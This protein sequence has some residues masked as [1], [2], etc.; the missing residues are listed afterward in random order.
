MNP[1][2]GS[3]DTAAAAGWYFQFADVKGISSWNFLQQV[4]G[5][6]HVSKFFLWGSHYMKMNKI[7]KSYRICK[8]YRLKS[9]FT[10]IFPNNQYRI[11]F[12]FQS[13]EETNQSFGSCC[14]SIKPFFF[15]S[16]F[17]SPNDGARKR[18]WSN[19]AFQWKFSTQ[20]RAVKQKKTF[21]LWWLLTTQTAT[22]E[23]GVK[24]AKQKPFDRCQRESCNKIK[25]LNSTFP[26]LL[27]HFIPLFNV[28]MGRRKKSNRKKTFGLFPTGIHFILRHP[29]LRHSRPK[30]RN[31]V[32]KRPFLPWCLASCC[33]GGIEWLMLRAAGW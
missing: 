21:P 17:I 2:A 8:T 26:H 25:S 27:L 32:N 1:T 20:E 24:N 28:M 31:S 10:D 13:L 29:Q 11:C 22:T 16:I 19:Q 7:P 30:S 3:A 23:R 15:Q 14:P 4:S 18:H 6:V 5:F 9:K 33:V 12:K